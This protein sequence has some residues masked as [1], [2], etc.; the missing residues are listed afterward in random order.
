MPEKLLSIN[1]VKN[2][3]MDSH[4]PMSTEEVVNS[5]D[6]AEEQFKTWKIL[7]VKSWRMGID[8]VYTSCIQLFSTSNV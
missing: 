2:K 7:S 5:I 8:D 1:P 3:V 4:I 6:F